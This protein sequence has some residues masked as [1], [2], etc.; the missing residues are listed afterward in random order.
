MAR[1]R[2]PRPEGVAEQGQPVGLQGGV[3]VLPSQG[4][5]LFPDSESLT[6]TTEPGEEAALS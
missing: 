2:M 3:A 4:D 6:E 5:A 1:S